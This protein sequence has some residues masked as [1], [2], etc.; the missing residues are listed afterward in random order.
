M[1][2]SYNLNLQQTQK[3]VM[4]P[5]LKQ[6]IEILQY[7]SMELN[8]FIQQ[9]LMSNPVLERQQVKGDSDN[10]SNKE[11]K[12]QKDIIDMKKLFSEY[13][14]SKYKSRVNNY[15]EK[16]EHSYENYL[17]TETTLTEHLLFQLQFT[18]L[19]GKSK[20]IGKY[21]VENING[22]GYLKISND[23]ICKK[24]NVEDK[25]VEDIIQIVQTFDPVGVGAGT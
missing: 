20:I 6:A 21:I 18:M 19:K 1:R 7:N 23:E 9:E 17:S 11:E 10:T 14:R 25:E 2:L 22:N 3:L 15:E 12:N 13:D 24:F 8:N 16:E 4:T 5:E